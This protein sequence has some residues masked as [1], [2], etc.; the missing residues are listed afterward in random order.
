VKFQAKNLLNPEIE[1]TQGDKT[2]LEFD[3]G[4][5]FSVS[6]QWSY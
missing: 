4:R 6:L 2:R 5:E 1:L 3:V